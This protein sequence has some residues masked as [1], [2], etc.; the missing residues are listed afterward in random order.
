LHQ[1]VEELHT[2]QQTSIDTGAL[3]RAL[4]LCEVCFYSKHFYFSKKKLDNFG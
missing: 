1:L 3:K 4:E 2:Q